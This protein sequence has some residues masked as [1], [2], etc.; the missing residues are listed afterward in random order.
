MLIPQL[1]IGAQG[2]D[3]FSYLFHSSGEFISFSTGDPPVLQPPF[4]HSDIIE[5]PVKQQE[6]PAGKEIAG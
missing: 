4:V 6:T 5:D 2:P 1:S 3:V